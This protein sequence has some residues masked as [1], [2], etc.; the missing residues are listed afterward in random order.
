[1]FK[2][3]SYILLWQ[4]VLHTWELLKKIVIKILKYVF[5]FRSGIVNFVIRKV[6]SNKNTL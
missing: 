6:E 2:Y 4:L 1:M 5:V 3:L